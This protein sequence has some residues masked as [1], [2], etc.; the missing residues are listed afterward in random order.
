VRASNVLDASTAA[1]VKFGVG[2]T[3]L[4]TGFR[5][6]SD[7]DYAR[8]VIA[9][10][11]AESPALDPSGTSWL[12][13]PFWIYGAGFALFG[14]GLDVARALALGL[15]AFS[16]VCVVVAAWLL[17]LGRGPALAAGVVA[18]VFPY[19]AYLGAA[20]VPE[21]P[22]SA[23][24]VL[25]AATLARSGK[26]RV[27]GA[28]ALGAACASRY[29]PWAAALVFA[30][31]T[32]VEAV[33]RRDRLL[34][35]A[36]AVAALFPLAWLLHGV[37]RH[38]DALF[39]LSRVAKYRAALGPDDPLF[40]RLLRTPSALVVS[41]P[42]LVLGSLGLGVFA[43]RALAADPRA[44]AGLR[45]AAC[46][47]GL[48]AMLVLGDALGGAPTHHG[49]R[50]LLSVW[51]SCALL[52]AWSGEHL[53]E[54]R[55]YGALAVSAAVALAAL[56]LVRPRFP[57]EGFVDRTAEVDIGRRARAHAIERL[58]IETPDFGY[59][60]VQAA[61]GE[62]RRTRVLDDH[63]PR[64]PR[65]DPALGQA[66]ALRRLADEGTRWL[67]VP[68]ARVSPTETFAVVRDRNQR[69]ALLDLGPNT[70]STRG[71]D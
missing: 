32:S 13:L 42:E 25:G 45:A 16:T 60:A 39:F 2:A 11:F 46:L 31:L 10:G 17:G 63:D 21:A 30:A 66:P 58:A 43:A 37:V 24:V 52:A 54:A 68:L 26:V 59:F 14:D 27:L 40:S 56:S 15:G 50:A 3:V 62:P 34:A 64:S 61:F 67:V 22:A 44:K 12:P 36:A 65:R 41:E 19:S 7:D 9:Q 69:F 28:L 29:E 33:K 71:S 6:V 23:L 8:L 18:S 4:A 35:L 57:R 51:L 20:F 49:E 5:A 48:F 55:K 38:G 53:L 70:S 47:L 1:A